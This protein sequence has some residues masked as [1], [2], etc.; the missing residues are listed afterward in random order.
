[1][2]SNSSGADGLYPFGYQSASATPAPATTDL[3]PSGM[4][5]E[6]T[7]LLV[8]LGGHQALPSAF[9]N[10]AGSRVSVPAKGVDR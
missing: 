5:D 8:H 7:D 10:L 6:L 9:K 2:V 1:M 4:P 3:A